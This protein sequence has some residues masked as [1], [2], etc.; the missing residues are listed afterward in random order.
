MNGRQSERMIKSS[1]TCI[2]NYLEEEAR[3]TEQ[4]LQV[5]CLARQNCLAAR[6]VL[7]S[8]HLRA[9]PSNGVRLRTGVL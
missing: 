2:D 1:I 9:C 5:T 8:V 3:G 6:F 4:A 7:Y